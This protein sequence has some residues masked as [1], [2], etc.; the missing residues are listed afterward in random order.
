MRTVASLRRPR[1]DSVKAL[2][3][4]RAPALKR[5]TEQA[6]RQRFWSE[7][8]AAHLSAELNAKL[9]GVTEQDGALIIFARSAAWCARLRYAVLELE[10][11]IR[12]AAP[13]LSEIQVRV[14]PR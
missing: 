5:V 9:S 8:L 7:W 11:Q 4:G 1:I 10:A 13:Q 14:L 2:L 12:A 3:A 6:A